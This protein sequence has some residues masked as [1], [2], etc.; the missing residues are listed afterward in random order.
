MPEENG[1]PGTN[2]WWDRTQKAFVTRDVDL[3][4]RKPMPVEV[5]LSYVRSNHTAWVRREDTQKVL[6]ALKGEA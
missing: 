5:A 6:D 3:G 2:I 1:I 4:D